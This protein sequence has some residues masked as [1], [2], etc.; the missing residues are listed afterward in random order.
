MMEEQ[1]RQTGRTKRMLL[2]VAATALDPQPK[3]IF[4]VAHRGHFAKDLMMQLIDVFSGLHLNRD[5]WSSY[6][7]T[8]ISIFDTEIYFLS[9]SN[10][11]NKKLCALDPMTNHAIFYD[12]YARR[13]QDRKLREMFNDAPGYPPK[14]KIAEDIDVRGFLRELGIDVKK[15][16]TKLKN[17]L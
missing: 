4:V 17:L 9:N 8:S 1:N 3:V 12:H 15:V 13:C 5:M 7:D 2:A 11:I 10:E 6:N 16:L 14:R